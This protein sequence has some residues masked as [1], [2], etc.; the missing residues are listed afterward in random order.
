MD[1][2]KIAAM[3]AAVEKG[4]LTSAARELGYTQSGLTHMM[5]ALE[6]ELGL[7]LLVR[8]KNGVHLSP[9]GQ[10]LLPH[11]K[12]L[13]E[14]S[15]ELDAAAGALRERSFATLRLGAYASVAGQWLPSVLAAFRRLSPE[16]DVVMDVGGVV[17]VYD[18]LKNDELD[19]AIV[20]YQEAL[21]Q[22]LQ[23]VPLADDALLAILP[24]GSCE[25][26]AFPLSG[27]EGREFLMPSF[28][29]NLDIDPLFEQGL[30]K[31]AS[32]VR[33]TNLDD[34][35]IVSMV[36]HGLGV[37]ILSTLIMRGIPENVQAL[38]LEPP[39]VRRLCI[40]M[41]ERRQND[42]N[43]RRFIRCAQSVVERLEGQPSALS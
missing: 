6:A 38:P 15:Q 22:G 27:F 24:P 32:R 33:H 13:L 11:I 30:E 16:T 9:A 43:I 21:C 42:R 37:S 1:T 5:N 4:S 19:C 7:N 8:S 41:S 14:A 12:K 28:D 40:A 29:F 10:E 39:A 17:E 26:A 25:T 3:L 35:G 20:S 18:K 36:A 31:I 34:A 23:V 2:K